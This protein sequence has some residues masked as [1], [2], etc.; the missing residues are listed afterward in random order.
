M[1]FSAEGS[2]REAIQAIQFE[3]WPDCQT[4]CPF[5]YLNGTKRTTTVLQ[6][7]KNLIDVL[8]TIK[9]Q[10]IMQDYNAVGLIGGEFFQGQL[11]D[12]TLEWSNLLSQLG[13]LLD[14]QKIK[15]VWIAS[16]LVDIIRSDLIGTL[17]AFNQLVLQQGQ[18]ITLC[19]SYDT[20]GRFRSNFDINSASEEELRTIMIESGCSTIE[21]L[22]KLM[23][24]DPDKVEEWLDEIKFIKENYQNITIHVQVILTQDVIERLIEDPNYF[25]FIT[26]LGC[27]I[28]FRY[29][30]ITRADCPTATVIKDYRTL[31]LAKYKTFPPKFFIEDRSVFLKFL[32]IFAEKYGLE[33]VRNLVHQPEMRSRRLK[34]YIDNAEIKDRW[35]D[36]RDVYLDCGHL[37]DGLCY[38]NDDTHCI[39][40]DIE[41]FIENQE[42][43]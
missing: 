15:E 42:N 7:K 26:D 39:Y 3:L 22:K 18:R 27:I 5:C 41:K 40:C 32:K 12:L 1:A 19:T 13:L 11:K 36:E 23:L 33:K 29:P 20:V 14:M 21:E 4:G 2:S 31:L 30:S 10:S 24:C 9:D 38:I 34:I 37:V 35:N 8:K 6:K 28:D 16:S 43:I 25:D 17:S